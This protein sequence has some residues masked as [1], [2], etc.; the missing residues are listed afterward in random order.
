MCRL[1][2]RFSFHPTSSS[3]S[4]TIQIDVLE[5]L[6]FIQTLLW[7]MNAAWISGVSQ[8]TWTP[9]NIMNLFP[10]CKNNHKYIRFSQEIHDR[11]SNFWDGTTR[12]ACSELAR[13]LASD[14]SEGLLRPPVGKG[15]K[16]K[17][18]PA[19]FGRIILYII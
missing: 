10:S 8:D 12:G 15:L 18:S 2:L 11:S 3:S 4:R 9:P 14:S 5:H 19:A 17:F 6:I 1:Q 16:R 13:G 7:K